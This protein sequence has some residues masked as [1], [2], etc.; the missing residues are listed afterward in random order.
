[1]HHEEFTPLLR[2]GGAQ[3]IRVNGVRHSVGASK[4]NSVGR[5]KTTLNHLA[6]PEIR[7]DMAQDVEELSS[8]DIIVP[9]SLARSLVLS[10]SLSFLKII[11]R[12]IFSRCH[13]IISEEKD[14]RAVLCV[15]LSLGRPD[16]LT[17]ML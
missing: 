9:L 13:V 1:M 7:G 14:I 10:L 6:S 11:S 2:L 17:R 3:P 12:T 8:I 4:T 16:I 15:C 5:V